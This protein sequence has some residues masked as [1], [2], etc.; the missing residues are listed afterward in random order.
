MMTATVEH[1]PV[2]LRESIELLAVRP[3][4]TYVDGT[5]GLGG[6]SHEILQRL[7]RGGQLIGLDRDAEAIAHARDRLSRLGGSFRLFH[8][9]F[10]CLLEVLQGLRIRAVDGILLDLGIS[11]Y[12]LQTP[13]RGF[14]FRLTGP[15]DMRMDRD[16]LTTAGDIVNSSDQQ[17]LIRIFREYGEESAARPI[18]SALLEQRRERPFATTEELAA[19]VES[20]K[21]RRPGT[22]I[23][24]ATKV[25]QALRIA[26]NGELIGLGRFLEEAVGWLNPGGRLVVIS[27]H[28]LEDRIV[29]RSF[30]RAAGQCICYQPGDLCQCPRTELVK[31]LTR[32]P[33][34]PSASET[35]ENPRARSAKLRAVERLSSSD[36]SEA[37]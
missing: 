37:Q 14:S 35:A 13:E 19:L 25:F 28:S 4:G 2:L 10:R 8:Q 7:H 36:S 22:K 31:I 9:D 15:L 29:K 23:H 26:V 20:V 12:Q 32:K 17:E 18:A 24:P 21:G 1:I 11:S 34:P 3:D 6:H 16:Q 5:I 30:R 27:F 33:L